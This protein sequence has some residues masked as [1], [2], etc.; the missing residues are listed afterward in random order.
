[1]IAE[2]MLVPSTSNCTFATPMLSEAVAESV[3]EE[4][5]TVEDAVGAVRATVGGEMVVVVN[6]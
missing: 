3:T 1:M 6:V 5:E 2:P 4:P